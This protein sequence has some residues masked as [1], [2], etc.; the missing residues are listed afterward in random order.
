[1]NKKLLAIALTAFLATLSH[2][3]LAEDKMEKERKG[4]KGR[5]GKRQQEQ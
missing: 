3:I 1:M 4:R 5:H 2:S